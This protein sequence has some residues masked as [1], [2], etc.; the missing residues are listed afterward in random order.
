MGIRANLDAVTLENQIHRK[1]KGKS[2]DDAYLTVTAKSSNLITGKR[3]AI[4][5]ASILIGI[6][7]GWAI[8]HF[9]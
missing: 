6:A 9:V 4:S 5:G 8:G 2:I 1:E 3:V 7:I